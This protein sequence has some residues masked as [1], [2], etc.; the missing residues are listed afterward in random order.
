VRFIKTEVEG[1][2]QK[3][4]AHKRS[5]PAINKT[6]SVIE[7]GLKSCLVNID[8]TTI[9]VET[10][11]PIN[12]GEKGVIAADADVLARNPLGATLADDDVTG[13]DGFTTVFFHAETLGITVATVFDATLTFLMSHDLILLRVWGLVN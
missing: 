8:P 5:P 4:R 10:H 13:D 1:Q 7:S 2:A 11:A 9:F 3:K 6:N 12:K